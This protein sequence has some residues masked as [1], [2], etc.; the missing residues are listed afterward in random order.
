MEN[1]SRWVAE[2]ANRGSR[3]VGK[4]GIGVIDRIPGVWVVGSKQKI[5]LN[6]KNSQKYISQIYV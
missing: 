4:S 6:L 3:S 2:A 1:G 5:A